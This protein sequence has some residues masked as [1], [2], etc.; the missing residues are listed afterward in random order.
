MTTENNPKIMVCISI[1]GIDTQGLAVFLPILEAMA[2]GIPVMASNAGSLPELI[3]NKRYTCSH[4]SAAEWA[5]KILELVEDKTA[6][7][8]ARKWGLYQ[9]QKFSWEKCVEEY[10]KIYT[11]LVDKAAHGR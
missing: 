10:M 2:C 7:E 4:E 9:S 1:V 8:E 5:E 3:E 11:S 6:Y